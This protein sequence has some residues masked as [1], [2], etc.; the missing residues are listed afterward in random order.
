MS[1]LEPLAALGLVC[2]IMQIISFAHETVSICKTIYR[3]GYP[4]TNLANNV[5]YL[6]NVSENLKESLGSAPGSLGKDEQELMDIANRSLAA[7]S[8]LRKEVENITTNT[9]KG[10]LISAISGG[11]KATFRKRRIERLERSML[12]CQRALE[13]RILLR[14]WYVSASRWPPGIS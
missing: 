2:N 11:L 8:S 5:A 10:K 6:A 3:T 1:G 9:S 12:D 13:S 7:A 4:D 14:I